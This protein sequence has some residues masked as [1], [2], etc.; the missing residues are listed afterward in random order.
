MASLKTKPIFFGNGAADT[1][2]L[3]IQIGFRVGINTGI[4]CRSSILCFNGFS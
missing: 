1:L 2:L 4:K 3:S